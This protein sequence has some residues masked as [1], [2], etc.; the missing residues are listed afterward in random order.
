MFPT[1]VERPVPIPAYDRFWFFHEEQALNLLECRFTTVIF[2][3]MHKPGFKSISTPPWLLPKHTTAH[4][5]F[6]Q[7]LAKHEEGEVQTLTCNRLQS[8]SK[9]WTVNL[10]DSTKKQQ[11]IQSHNGIGVL[12]HRPILLFLICGSSLQKTF[13]HELVH[14]NAQFKELAFSRLDKVIWN[15]LV[16]EISWVGLLL[17]FHWRLLN[18]CSTRCTKK[19]DYKSFC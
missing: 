11:G 14:E 15:I 7:L 3:F 18:R 10:Q 4:Y 5:Y 19:K 16:L 9:E 6:G 2:I 12:W 8:L 17:A 1:Q 13:D